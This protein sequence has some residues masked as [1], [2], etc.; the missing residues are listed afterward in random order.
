MLSLNTAH[1]QIHSGRW[2]EEGSKARWGYPRGVL[3]AQ[4]LE[5]GDDSTSLLDV[6]SIAPLHA[7][8]PQN[9]CCHYATVPAAMAS[10]LLSLVCNCTCRIACHL[11]LSCLLYLT[12]PC[13]I[14]AT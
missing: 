12:T 5:E 8:P 1:G 11:H 13:C 10:T 9:L 14:V 4:Q 2:R 7:E 3:E 6:L